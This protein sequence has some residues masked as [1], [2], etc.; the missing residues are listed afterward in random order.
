MGGKQGILHCSQPVIFFLILLIVVNTTHQQPIKIYFFLFTRVFLT[1]V[2]N[3]PTN[4]F[5]YDSTKNFFCSFVEILLVVRSVT[6]ENSYLLYTIIIP[7]D[8]LVFINFALL[9]F[10]II[11][12]SRFIYV[13]KNRISNN[14][15]IIEN[16]TISPFR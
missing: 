2:K 16:E 15:T 9:I 4:P 5:R 11:L 1:L 7:Y 6:I 3:C 8:S 10:V 14:I 12:W 13:N